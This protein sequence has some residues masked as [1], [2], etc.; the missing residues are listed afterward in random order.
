MLESKLRSLDSAIARVPTRQRFERW[1]RD[2]SRPVRLSDSVWFTINPVN[3][4]LGEVQGDRSTAI[5]ALRL[6]AQPKIVTGNRPNDFELFTPLP[7]LST[8]KR[9]GRGLRV[10]LEGEL[11][12]DVASVILRRAIVGREIDLGPRTVRIDDIVVSG[13]GLGRVALGVRFGG[14]V[15]GNVY[16]TG[17]PRYDATSD[18]LLVPDLDYDLGTADLLVRG[19]QWLKDDAIRNFL[20]DRARFPVD[21]QLGRLREL[22]ERGMNRTLAPGVE[23]S[24]QLDSAKAISVRATT[25]MLF[26]RALAT[27]SAVLLVDR[28]PKAPP[29]ARKP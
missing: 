27:G 20:R 1:W 22:A 29:T 24:A 18:Q 15:K 26:V 6:E 19:L 10:S 11:G 14:S 23:L 13:I 7:R 25:K 28:P 12:Y 5:A 21:D 16:F 2:I 4:E 9:V 8:V 3:V 17:T